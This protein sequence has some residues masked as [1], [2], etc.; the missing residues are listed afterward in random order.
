MTENSSFNSR[1]P[2]DAARDEIDTLRMK[3]AAVKEGNA[4]LESDAAAVVKA[5]QL[6]AEAERLR[7]E[8]AFEERKRRALV[9]QRQAFNSPTVERV[10]APAKADVVTPPA[11]PVP[12]T[13]AGATVE[14]PVQESA[15]TLAAEPGT[16]AIIKEPS[17]TSARAFKA[18]GE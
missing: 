9:E 1:N 11:P 7:A 14:V 8:I 4:K 5:R 16:D 13:E 18:K 2:A 10:P 6:N 17:I 15:S 12:E 3:L